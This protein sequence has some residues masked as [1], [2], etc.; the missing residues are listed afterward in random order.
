[1]SLVTTEPPRPA[2]S[3]LE[4]LRQSA[5]EACRM[6]RV[7]A[8]PDRLLLLCRIAQSEVC[9]S[10][11][12]RELSIAQPTLSQQLAVLRDEA[13]VATRRE[14]KHIHYRIANAQV[15]AIM[16]VLYQQFCSPQSTFTKESF[17]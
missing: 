4:A 1:M 12:E 16:A 11:L 14:G 10:D 6:L 8:N 9:V 17:L 5:G 13:L 3:D 15:L 7:L 2:V